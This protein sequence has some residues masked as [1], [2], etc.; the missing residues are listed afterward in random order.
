MSPGPDDFTTEVTPIL[1]N[2]LQKTEERRL[3]NLFYE[4]EQDWIK[5]IKKEQNKTTKN[6]RAISLMNID[7][8]NS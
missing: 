8:K 7:I 4:A 6:Y 1:H 3:P 5:T 2:L